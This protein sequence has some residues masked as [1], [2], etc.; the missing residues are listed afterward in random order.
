[1]NICPECY[2]ECEDEVVITYGYVKMNFCPTDGTK[3]QDKATF[4]ANEKANGE[5]DAAEARELEDK[6]D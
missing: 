5:D 1:M 3:L 4:E 2:F 6:N